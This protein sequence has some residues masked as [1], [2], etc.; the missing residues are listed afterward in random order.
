MAK[1]LQ[2]NIYKELIPCPNLYEPFGGHIQDIYGL[3]LLKSSQPPAEEDL[4]TSKTLRAIHKSYS[5]GP[6]EKGV[7]NP[8][9]G[10]DRD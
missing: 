9:I 8:V 5:L 7:L 4:H 10:E 1:T 6:D 2:K 3:C